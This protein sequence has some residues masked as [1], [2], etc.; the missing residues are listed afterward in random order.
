MWRGCWIVVW[1]HISLLTRGK[2]VE[3]GSWVSQVA[4]GSVSPG[5]HCFP[6]IL[7]SYASPSWPGNGLEYLLSQA[8]PELVSFSLSEFS[9][10]ATYQPLN[11]GAGIALMG[12]LSCHFNYSGDFLGRFHKKRLSSL[13]QIWEIP[14]LSPCFLLLGHSLKWPY[15]SNTWYLILK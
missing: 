11:L 4:P 14:R 10:I 7:H 12:N 15:R 13:S 9:A 8:S 2:P 6:T 5:I 1:Y 3:A